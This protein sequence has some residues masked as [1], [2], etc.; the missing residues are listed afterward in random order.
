MSIRNKE[1]LFRDKF[2]GWDKDDE[3]YN[4]FGAQ[5]F[6]G[7]IF[8]VDGYETRDFFF[9]RYISLNVQVS[10]SRNFS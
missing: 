9:K 4:L 8:I 1:F 3:F 10:H 7:I 6:W 5:D 2:K